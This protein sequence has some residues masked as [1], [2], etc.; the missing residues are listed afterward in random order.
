MFLLSSEIAL[1]YTAKLVRGKWAGKLKNVLIFASSKLL[2]ISC[3][4]SNKFL[5]CGQK[6]FYAYYAKIVGG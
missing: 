4:Y 2:I 1:E 6:L 5:C 3:N